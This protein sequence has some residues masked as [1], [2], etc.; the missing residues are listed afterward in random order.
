GTY[1]V[2][3]HPERGPDTLSDGKL[4]ARFKAAELLSELPHRQQARRRIF[5][6][7]A[8]GS[9]EGLF[10]RFDDKVAGAVGGGVLSTIRIVLQ[11]V[12]APAV[13]TDADVESPFC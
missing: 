13:L 2:A 8:A 4:D 11:L 10:D 1:I 12:I 3:E 5:A 9:G 7:D 6:G